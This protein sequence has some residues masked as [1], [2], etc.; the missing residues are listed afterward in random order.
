VSTTGSELA[1]VYESS[2]RENSR[3]K[4]LEARAL[5]MVDNPSNWRAIEAL[6]SIL[7]KRRRIAGPEAWDIIRRAVFAASPRSPSDSRIARS[8]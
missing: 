2:R 1:T 8:A 6:A 4:I 3:R 7:F 5:D